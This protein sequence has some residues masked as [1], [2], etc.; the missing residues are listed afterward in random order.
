MITA[1]HKIAC[2][3]IS[4][5]QPQA[6]LLAVAEDCEQGGNWY[7]AGE[8]YSEL[9]ELVSGDNNARLYSRAAICF[10]IASQHRESAAAYSSAAS[11]ITDTRPQESGELL[12]RAAHQ[13]CLAHEYFSAGMQWRL[14]AVA[15]SK[16]GKAVLNRLD[17]IQPVPVSAAGLTISGYCYI[18]S[19]EALSKTASEQVWACGSYWEAGRVLEKTFPAPNIQ[20]FN[21]YRD[22]LDCCARFYG[23][24]KL[25]ELRKSLP[26][27]NEER[28]N[29]LDP[30]LVLEKAAFD[31][32]MHHSSNPIAAKI[33]AQ[34]EL[35]TA[36]HRFSNTLY[37]TGNVSEAG[38]QRSNE[39]ERRRRIFLLD[40]QYGK[41]ELY[42]F[43]KMTSGYG[44]SLFRWIVFCSAVTI[45]FAA[46]FWCFNAI[47]PV[48]TNFDY[49]YF[50]L[51]TFTTLG[52]SDIQSAN[53]AGKV[54]ICVEIIFGVVMAGVL[55]SFIGN[56]LQRD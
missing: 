2:E 20:T 4:L 5:P 40:G 29:K 33:S 1:K 39:K 50:S 27:T 56:R 49:L 14:A 15:F 21:A 30:F 13:S 25:D 38:E 19:G 46:L 11:A 35:L 47:K 32:H 45:G 9:A 54:L 48:E 28:Q 52:A 34:R 43:W 17:N 12:N 3:P 41:A 51:V 22:A 26:L 8:K 37:N 18:A 16:L 42:L 31:C 24:L 36:F 10:E 55:L 7:L 6:T 53:L 44:E 23:T